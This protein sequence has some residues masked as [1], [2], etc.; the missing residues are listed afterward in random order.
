MEK[1]RFAELATG[2]EQFD[3]QHWNLLSLVELLARANNVYDA[4]NIALDLI[5]LWREHH[6]CEEQWMRS[7]NIHAGEDHET[8]HRNLDILFGNLV[9]LV[10]DLP[11]LDRLPKHA[12]LLV[13]R[14]KEHIIKHDLQF[15]SYLRPS[16]EHA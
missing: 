3:N 1:E 15:R 6:Q 11:F 7:V 4:H 12:D 13:A 8:E 2:H 5:A 14:L 10:R 9:Y 16:S